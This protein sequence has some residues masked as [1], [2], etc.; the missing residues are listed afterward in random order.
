MASRLIQTRRL[1]TAAISVAAFLA[2]VWLP[3]LALGQANNVGL[4]VIPL[5]ISNHYTTSPLFVWIFGVTNQAATGI[6]KGSNVYVTNKN[7]DVAI[8][9]AIPANKPKSLGISVGT[10]TA[11]DLMLPKLSGI[12]IYTSVGAGLLTQNGGKKGNGLA[13]PDVENP[14]DPNFKTIFDSIETTWEDQAPIPGHPEV[15][16]NLGTNVTEVDLF[17]LVQQ[18][19]A[20]G[21]D[22]ATFKPAT[23]TAGFLST[24][25]RPALFITLRGFKAPWSKLILTSGG[26][27]LR[28]VSPNHG[29]HGTIPPFPLFPSDQLK[30]YIDQVFIHYTTAKLKT[31]VSVAQIGGPT[32]TYNFTGTTAGGEFFFADPKK[33]G[34]KPIFSLAKWSTF[35]AYEGHFPF[36]T[37][38]PGGSECTAPPLS[39]DCLAALAVEAKL[40]GAVMRTNLLANNNLDACVKSQFY[41]N[42]PVNKYAQLWHTSGIGGRAYGFGFD[43]TCDQ[44]S[45]ELIFNPTKLTITLPGARP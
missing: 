38:K 7:G 33:N 13:T 37:V 27:D 44:S 11:A 25:R 12:R 21:I 31:T 41:V 18:Y 9:P 22:P 43:D 35:N 17:G 28:V 6:P 19:T 10:G 15:K 29:I 32:V 30:S 8:N 39:N 20:A 4:P 16:T 34:G 14:G 23:K 5:H 1:A 2:G 40:Q 36:G 26:T 45:F 24:A 42:P 3:N